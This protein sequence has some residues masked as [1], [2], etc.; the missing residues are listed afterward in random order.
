MRIFLSP[1][2]LQ[3]HLQ[4]HL[5]LSLLASSHGFSIDTI[6]HSFSL[7]AQSTTATTAAAATI[8]QHFPPSLAL[9]LPEATRSVTTA[10][11]HALATH[12]LE[13]QVATGVVLAVVGDGIAQKATSDRYDVKRALSFCAFDGAYRSVQH[14]VYPYMIATCHGQV[15]GQ[16]LAGDPT[17]NT[18]LAAS[19]EQALVS[20]L[21]IIPTLYYPFF[22]AVTGAVQGLS[23]QETLERAKTTFVPLM[24]RNL[25]FWI[26]VQFGVFLTIPDQAT[27]IPVLIGFGLIWTVILSVLAGS[28]KPAS[29]TIP[30]LELA[31]PDEEIIMSTFGTTKD[32]RM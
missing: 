9:L 26:P 25:V 13:T 11:Q 24:T 5:L 27:Q 8:S 14:Y 31:V 23:P 17:T 32:I 12:A 28:A 2:S 30:P 1:L 22:F 16:V 21:V 6:V 10:Y 15:L 18:H 4:L 20:Q 3:L 7:A 29:T 19:I